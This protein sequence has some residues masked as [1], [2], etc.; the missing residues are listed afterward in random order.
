MSTRF[1]PWDAKDR[2]LQKVAE[3]GGVTGERGVEG[4]GVGQGTD[5]LRHTKDPGHSSQ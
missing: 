2:G 5:G 1:Q 4:Q 3:S